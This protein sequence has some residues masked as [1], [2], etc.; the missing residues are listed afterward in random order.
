MHQKPSQ[1]LSIGYHSPSECA[2]EQLRRNAIWDTMKHHGPP[3]SILSDHSNKQSPHSYR[4]PTTDSWLC[5]HCGWSCINF[6]KWVSG[7]ER[8][9]MYAEKQAGVVAELTLAV[10]IHAVGRNYGG[11]MCMEV[12]SRG[13]P[14][15]FKK[16]A[17]L[18]HF[19]G[20]LCFPREMWEQ[21]NRGLQWK[22]WDLL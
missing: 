20:G 13:N 19:V 8:V 6:Y 11:G 4:K 22:I 12:I 21:R 10:T 16:K 14:C 2:K 7:L 15:F 17:K 3:F 18:P 5:T 9:M 1:G